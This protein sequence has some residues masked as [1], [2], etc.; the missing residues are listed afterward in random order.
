MESIDIKEEPVAEVKRLKTAIRVIIT[1]LG[2]YY[3][4]RNEAY[5][6]DIVKKA[7]EFE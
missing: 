6:V 5:L 2:R 3:D 7:E 4:T 1:L